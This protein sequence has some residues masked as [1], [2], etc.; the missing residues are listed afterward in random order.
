MKTTFDVK[1]I[2][3]VALRLKGIIRDTPLEYSRRLSKKYKAKIYLKRE[4][5]Q[6]VR[7]YKLRGAYN[8]LSTLTTTEKKKG[9]V[10]ASAGNHAQGVAFGCAELKIK[11]HIFMPN[12]SPRQKIERVLLF[13]SKFVKLELVGE[14]FGEAYKHAMG[15]SK[16][17]KRA[18]INPFDDELV[19]AGQG[20][21]ALD[22]F[23]QFLE[24]ID[25]MMV[26]IGGGGLISGVGLYTKTKFPKCKIVG[27]E[28]LG[29][30]TM[31][32]SIRAG[33]VQELKNMDTF[34]DGAAVNKAG[35]L[36]FEMTKKYVD[37]IVLVHEGRICQEVIDF[38]Q[39]DG[40][41]TEPAGALSVSALDKI[42]DKI[43]GKTVVCV[44]SGGNNDLSRYQEIIERSLIYRGL[45]HYFVLEISQRP[46]AFKEFVN[47]ILGPTDDMTL[48]EYAKKDNR[49]TGPALIGVELAKKIDLQP[50]LKR[51]DKAG[52]EY[53]HLDEDSAIRRFGM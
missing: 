33:K 28:P 14:S 52:F 3:L 6:P 24:K 17:T 42:K 7:S 45:K 16:K 46:G 18:F 12:N 27:A 32:N 38:Y 20:T 22:I 40:I 35:K 11:A 49:E 37:Q 47:D 53:E 44:V 2:E 51:M 13:G 23:S 5:L 43:V 31:L 48:V 39:S 30:P 10:C 41:V 21:I 36:T 25:Y 15:F 9:V 1:Q 4:D 50:L 34:V 8:K 29:A 19:I 26:P